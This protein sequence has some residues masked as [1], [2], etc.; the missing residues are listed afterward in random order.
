MKATRVTHNVVQ[1]TRLRFV[2]AYLHDG[3]TLVEAATDGSA[4]AIIAA[5]AREDGEIR[6]IALTHGHAD[7]V[8]SLDAL[9]DRLGSSVEVLMPEVD[10]RIHA[11]ERV[12]EGKL[13]GAWPKLRTVQ[14]VRLRDGDRVGSLVVIPSP[15]HT[16]GHVAFLDTRDGALIAG[17]TFTS[18]GRVAV[19]SRFYLRF[20]LAAMASWDK[21]MVVESARRL[22]SL[23]PAVLVVGHGPA[24]R[25]PGRVMDEAIARSRSP[26]SPPPDTA[27]TPSVPLRSKRAL[28]R[29][30]RPASA[31][32]ARPRRCRTV[33]VSIRRT[34]R[35]R[36]RV[37]GAGVDIHRSPC[38]CSGH[39]RTS[40][41]WGQ[42][43]P[44]SG[45]S[46][47]RSAIG[48]RPSTLAATYLHR[49]RVPVLK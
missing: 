14:E 1:L 30:G 29:G 25:D 15:G 31:P 41:V 2:N 19:T 49:N 10:A 38:H 13:P 26:P 47:P 8:G 39:G 33:A 5:A 36:H 32:P 44:I 6:R 21:A 20:P 18:Y 34:L 4:A 48:V 17:D 35:Q 3:F 37:G 7:H 22:V 27:R 24:V 12:V 11:G 46:N 9:T 45:Q 40:F 28:A 16:P 23:D 43:E 42:P